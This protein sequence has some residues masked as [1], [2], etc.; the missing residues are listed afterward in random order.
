MDVALTPRMQAPIQ[1][2]E[3]EVE[4]HPKYPLKSK[5]EEARANASRR[6]RK[7]KACESLPADSNPTTTDWPAESPP[8]S[9]C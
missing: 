5:H 6:A 4:T 7:W 1:R 3:F 2:A 8:D 9:Q